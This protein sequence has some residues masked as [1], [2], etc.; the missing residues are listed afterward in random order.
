MPT[1]KLL[2]ETEDR[3][4]KS[5]DVVRREFATVRTGRASISMVDSLKIDYYGTSTGLKQLASITTP[6]ARLV[7]IQPWD[8]TSIEAIEKAILQ[9]DLGI[10]PNNDGKVIRLSVPQLSRERREELIKVI[11]KKAEDG[12]IA[13]RSVRRDANEQI[14]RMKK[15]NQL[16]ED[17]VF[18]A[19]DFAQDLTNKYI[20]EIDNIFNGKEKELLSM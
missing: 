10:T 12:R 15:N 17:D 3:M 6:E 1:K 13:L 19:Q 14:A 5:V 4:K 11:K 9:S 2:Y 8:P 20:K 18:D 16:T 7:M